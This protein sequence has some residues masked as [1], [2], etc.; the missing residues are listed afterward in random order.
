MLLFLL[1][2][3]LFLGLHLLQAIAPGVRDAAVASLGRLVYRIVH[4]VL[5]IAT[6]CLLIYGFGEARQETGILY[7]PPLFLTH[8]TL[9]L[10]LIAVIV[11]VSSFLPA[12]YIA[13][14]TKHPMVTS[15]K[16]WALAHLLAN[17]ETVQVILFA[18][19]LAWAVIVRISYKKRMARGEALPRPYKSWEYD[20]AAVIIGLV[21]YGAI[22]M[23]LHMLLIG[24]PVMA[25]G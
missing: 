3:V 15:V 6:L 17:G 9:T 11:L 14:K 19:F 20:I 18:A 13:A 10:M 2:L 7:E 12:G 21:V 23:K 22:V 5:S 8:I 4:S 16:I 25:M 1:G 24:V